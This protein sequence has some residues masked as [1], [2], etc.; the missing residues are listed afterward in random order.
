MIV[1]A[2]RP[3]RW[4]IK[5][6]SIWQFEEGAAFNLSLQII[7]N[8][9]LVC[10]HHKKSS[11]QLFLVLFQ[12]K[13]F[14]IPHWCYFVLQFFWLLA[15]GVWCAPLVSDG[16]LFLLRF[17]CVLSTEFLQTF[18]PTNSMVTVDTGLQNRS[19]G[20]GHLGN[21]SSIMAGMFSNV[22]DCKLHYNRPSFIICS[23][24]P[25]QPGCSRSNGV[26]LAMEQRENM[27]IGTIVLQTTVCQSCFV[28]AYLR[29]C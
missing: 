12:N 8:C 14:L 21:S 19:C 2:V 10:N 9:Y 4:T 13:C 26:C 27:S 28:L 15:P 6:K 3:P 24:T 20:L 29:Y 17:S 22:S 7:L 11:T 5:V 1:A 23:L 18:Y 16:A 25:S